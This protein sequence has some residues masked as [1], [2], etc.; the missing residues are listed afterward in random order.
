[1]TLLHELSSLLWQRENLPWVASGITGAWILYLIGLG[2]YRLYFS[3]LSKFPGPKL[4]A[5]TQW[6]EVYFDV[7]KGGGGQFTFEIQRMHEKYGMA[8]LIC[9]TSSISFP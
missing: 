3:P 6:Y 9:F 8:I 1:M 7:V 5:L 4:A 2:V